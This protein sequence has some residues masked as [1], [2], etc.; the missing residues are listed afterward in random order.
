M[1]AETYTR[2]GHRVPQRVIT[3]DAINIEN[4]KIQTQLLDYYMINSKT[5]THYT[6]YTCKHH[7][8][9]IGRFRR[10]LAYTLHK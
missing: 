1:C 2:P 5:A 3:A 4:I 6:S 8:N 10:E 9:D 7:D